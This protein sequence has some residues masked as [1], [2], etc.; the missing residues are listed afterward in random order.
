MNP[1]Q[2]RTKIRAG[3]ASED[4]GEQSCLPEDDEGGT[5]NLKHILTNFYNILKE[6]P[7]GIESIDFE[8]KLSQRLGYKFEVKQHGCDSVLEFLRKV[9]MPTIDIEILNTN[10]YDNSKFVLRSKHYLTHYY[11]QHYEGH[12]HPPPGFEKPNYQ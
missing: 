2:F 6:F 9:I 7:F 10:P 5:E 4:Y 1:P 12:F 3:Y 8:N 11:G